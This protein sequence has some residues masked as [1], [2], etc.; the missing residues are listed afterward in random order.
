MDKRPAKAGERIR[1]VKLVL[2]NGMYDVGDEFIVDAAATDRS[3][4]VF[5]AMVATGPRG[6]NPKGII[7]LE[8]YIVLEATH[9]EFINSKL[10]GAT[11][12]SCYSYNDELMVEFTNGLV[13][14]LSAL[15]RHMVDATLVRK[16]V[17]YVEM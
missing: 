6:N 11:F 12:K 3:G 10:K 7:H 4:S 15:D 5:V 9:M 16:E 2:S 13:I 17:T 1:I 14:K 8:E